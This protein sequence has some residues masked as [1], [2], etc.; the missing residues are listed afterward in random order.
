MVLVLMWQTKPSPKQIS[1]SQVRI[2][3]TD[4]KPGTLIRLSDIQDGRFVKLLKDIPDQYGVRI[5]GT[6]TQEWYWPPSVSPNT[7]V[8]CTRTVLRVDAP[9]LWGR[10][11]WTENCY[12][13]FG[14]QRLLQD[15][16]WA[17]WYSNQ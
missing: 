10:G 5:V 11:H 16:A 14:Q 3:T 2:G 13:R 7:K 6:G 8:I 9:P 12:T 4:R 15:P 17:E 1:A